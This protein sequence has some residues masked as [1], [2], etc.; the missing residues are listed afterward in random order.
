[1]PFQAATLDAVLLAAS[2][3]LLLVVD[4][5][6]LCIVA[7]NPKACAVLGYTIEK[8]LGRP[9][10]EIESALQD[11]FYWSEVKVGNLDEI[12][13]AEG[14]YA[15]ADGSLVSVD[16]SVRVAATAEGRLLAIR[17]RDSHARE[18]SDADLAE[19]SSL[20]AATLESTAEGILV[21]DLDKR[22]I[23]FNRRFAAIWRIEDGM[24]HGGD[25]RAILR[26][27][28]RQMTVGFKSKR[29]FLWLLVSDEADTLDTFELTDDRTIECRSRPQLMQDRVLGRVFTF[30]DVTQ[31]KQAERQLRQ[32]KEA[33]DAANSAKSAFLATMSHEIRTPMNG[34]IG[35]AELLA[36]SGLDDEQGKMLEVIQDS[37]HALLHIINDILDLSRIEAGKLE[38]H[39]EPLSIAA[40]LESVADILAPTATKNNLDFSLTIDPAIPG[41]LLGDPIRL[42]QIVF[43]LGGN[44]LKFTASRADRRGHVGIRATLESGGVEA[45]CSVRFTVQ[46]NGIG[47]TEEAVS[48]LFQPF[49]Q[50]DNTTTRRFGGSGLGLS[51]CARLVAMMGGDIAVESRPNEGSTFTVRLPF[52]PAQAQAEAKATPVSTKPSASPPA[53]GG[54]ILVAED[55][56][57]NQDIIARQLGLLGYTADIAGDGREAL[58]LLG[59]K[60]YVLLLSDCQMPEMDG[61]ELTRTIRQQEGGQRHLPIIA[62]TANV[63]ARDIE[64]CRAAGMD[65]VIG[66]PT[67]LNDLKLILEHWLSVAQSANSK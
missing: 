41:I 65:D 48:R 35:M 9:I 27:L 30:T 15:C 36:T 57:I 66:K 56:E 51:I 34:I 25:D 26:H 20:L 2:D 3:E 61:F 67:K 1:M 19:A 38:I 12:N 59:R 16:K 37:A 18:R 4:P 42:R 11:V 54:L 49:S 24:L 22:I 46:D 21:L 29:R 58:A 52:L 62:Y 6:T 63:L 10:T 13:H 28:L 23:N 43:N 17:A 14:L 45:P 50:A 33:A 7:A 32:A 39:N 40:T 53:T 31:R 5:A 44:A 55:N 8:L 64:Q 60:D 47:M